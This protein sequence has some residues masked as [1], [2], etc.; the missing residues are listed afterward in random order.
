M[1][2]STVGTKTVK[3]TEMRMK[4]RKRLMETLILT[5]I[6]LRRT[7]RTVSSRIRRVKMP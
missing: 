5:M 1:K 7:T 4:S 2:M 6:T 3:K